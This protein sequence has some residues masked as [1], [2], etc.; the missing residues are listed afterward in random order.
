MGTDVSVEGKK[1][2]ELGAGLS[3]RDEKGSPIKAEGLRVQVETR[4]PGGPWRAASNL[5]VQHAGRPA[6]DVMLVADN[7]GSMEAELDDIRD[8]MSGFADALIGRARGDRVGVVRVSTEAAV[9]ANLT[10]D[11]ALIDAATAGMYTNQGWTALWDGIRLANETLERRSVEVN[12]AASCLLGALPMIITMTDGADNNSS[13]EH[14]TR[15][16]GDGVDTT[17][18]DLRS[19]SVNGR[20]TTLHTVAVGED[21][22][23][24][25]LRELAT[26]RQGHFTHIK[27]YGALLNALQ[28]AAAQ[29]DTIVPVCFQPAACADSEARIGVERRDVKGD[30]AFTVVKLPDARCAP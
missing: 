1:S 24:S 26:A 21:A 14:A 6:L 16:P 2:G 27:N 30:M 10:S 25:A 15:Y 28:A 22:D 12:G 5:V 8:A 18:D 7:S 3:V 13:D 20:S 9:L 23:V 29:L 4:T 17:L 11:K 19:L